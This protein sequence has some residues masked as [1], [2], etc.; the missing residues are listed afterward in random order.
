M[1]SLPSARPGNFADFFSQYF[2]DQL[3]ICGL[4]F[5]SELNQLI[6]LDLPAGRCLFIVII[7]AL[8][9][10]T[11]LVCVA[12]HSLVSAQNICQNDAD[13]NGGNFPRLQFDWLLQNANIHTGA[14]VHLN[15]PCQ[16]SG[17]ARCCFGAANLL[18]EQTNI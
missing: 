4:E 8:V 12:L 16:G 14:R 3:R 13:Q 7:M 1:T 10:K 2:S 11:F 15:H 18:Q 6:S 9:F 17:S 5:R